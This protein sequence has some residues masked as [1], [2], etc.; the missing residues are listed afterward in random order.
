MATRPLDARDIEDVLA[1]QAACPEMAQWTAWDYDRAARGEMAA[2]VAEG[3]GGEIAGFI[4]AR[5]VASDLEILNFAVRPSLRRQGVGGALLGE[6]L[7]WAQTFEAQQAFL[8]VRMSNLAALRFYE[9]H[10]FQVS[11]RRPRYYTA[12]IEDALL[13]SLSL[14]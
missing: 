14:S 2:W 8:E 1:I 4:V 9:R 7:R 5:R 6:A 10:N 11:G 13:L 12:P 3:E